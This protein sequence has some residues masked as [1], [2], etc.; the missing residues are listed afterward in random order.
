MSPELLFLFSLLQIK[1]EIRYESF[2]MVNLYIKLDTE[3]EIP[4]LS[5]KVS[6][7]GDS[8]WILQNL[9]NCFFLT[10]AVI[11]HRNIASWR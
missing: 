4:C 8:Y 10:Y 9:V 2:L 6:S 7:A 1:L 5:V 11:Q 3:L